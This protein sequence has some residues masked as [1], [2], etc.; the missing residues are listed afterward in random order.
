MSRMNLGRGFV[1]LMLN[2][3]M[4]GRLGGIAGRFKGFV[5]GLGKAFAGLSAG[6]IAGAGA[7]V[8][9]FGS[10]EQRMARVQAITGATVNEF[11][12]LEGVAE[13]LG[14]TT[15]FSAS[16]AAEAMGN[17]AVSGLTTKEIMGAMPDVL[18][19]AAAGQLDMATASDIGAKIMRGMGLEA[20][21]L[22]HAIDVMAK[23]FTTSN[24]DLQMLGEA[25]KFI[26]PVAQTTGKE[27]EEITAAIQVL[28]NVGIQ[29]AM[30]G[31][32][33]RGALSRLAGATG[34]SQKILDDLSITFKDMHGNML[35]LHVIVDQFNNSMQMMGEAE[36][37][38]ILM[39]VFGQRA[40]PGMAELLNQGGDA[41]REMEKNLR[42]SAGT[43]ARIAEVQ[44]DTL[45]GSFTRLKSV[46]EGVAIAVGRELAPLVRMIADDFGGVTGALGHLSGFLAPVMDMLTDKWVMF[47]DG[48]LTAFNDIMDGTRSFG[49]VLIDTFGGLAA[50]ALRGFTS[51][52]TEAIPVFED[53]AGELAARFAETFVST[54][55]DAVIASLPSFGDL[56]SF[57]A[58]APL[59]GLRMS[60]DA[61]SG[62]AKGALQGLGVIGPDTP[63]AA[64]QAA[65]AGP[66]TGINQMDRMVG[67][68]E[69]M[70]NRLDNPRS[71]PAVLG[72]VTWRQTTI[73]SSRRNCWIGRRPSRPRTRKNR[74]PSSTATAAARC[75]ACCGSRTR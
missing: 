19:L 54:A 12:A 25:F 23:A 27:I 73:S 22:S 75:V 18:N 46:A 30:A 48:A 2:D 32:T 7:A 28:S 1:D 17:L 13:E 69:R 43:A 61:I 33:L 68:L 38:G 55:K 4:S 6:G 40:G 74:T 64:G 24:T 3:R 34:K 15:Q 47:R 62:V 36:R 51:F 31:T 71:A 5:G 59:R 39:T 21:D 60:K 44:M 20:E 35:P 56:G 29:G 66:R 72:D 65:A 53:M 45:F 11:A 9:I 52:V 37:L 10:F 8:A 67:I 58:S 63:A 16:Q 26:G 70:A 49:D 42:N 50:S 14:R 41:L 57:L